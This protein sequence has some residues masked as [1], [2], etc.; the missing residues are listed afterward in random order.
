VQFAGDRPSNENMGHLI[1]LRAFRGAVVS[2]A[3]HLSVEDIAGMIDGSLATADR[4]RAER[5]LVECDECREELA[6]CTRVVTSGV[7]PPVRRFPWRHLLP[8][9]AGILVVVWLRRPA[10]P[11][12]VS[13]VS[14]RAAPSMGS[15]IG[16]VFPAAGASVAAGALHF[17]C[18][19]IDGCEG[20]HVV[21]KDASGAP[22][23][24]GDVADTTLVLP[25]SVRLEL[26]APYVWRVDGERGDGST[27][28]SA[29]SGFRI[30]P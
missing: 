28:A 7:A 27:A 4:E 6:T 1:L 14:E 5:H 30:T 26:N 8:L 12:R 24:S 16:T 29:E 20:Y 19:P 23:W 22:V 10:T 13:D 21:V 18:H 25:D 11:D 15:R 3:P 2:S 9:A 17:A